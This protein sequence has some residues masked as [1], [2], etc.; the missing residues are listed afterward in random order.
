MADTETDLGDGAQQRVIEQAKQIRS[1]T[2]TMERE[3]DRANKA[4]KDVAELQKQIETLQTKPE[5]PTGT[6]ASGKRATDTLNRRLGVLTVENNKL[7]QD[8]TK[9]THALTRE[10]GDGQWTVQKV[11]EEDS[12]WRGRAQQIALLRMKLKQA[13]QA[14]GDGSAPAA[15]VDGADERNRAHLEDMKQGMRS[16]IT[17]LEAELEAERRASEATKRHN[18]SLVARA[19]IIERDHG[20]MR[21]KLKLLVQKTQ[22]DNELIERLQ[23]AAAGPE[24]RAVPATPGDHHDEEYGAGA[25]DRI[26]E[27][28]ADLQARDDQLATAMAELDELRRVGQAEEVGMESTA[29]YQVNALAVETRQLQETADRYKERNAEL[30]QSLERVT[31][32]FQ[33]ERRSRMK[34]DRELGQLKSAGEPPRPVEG[35]DEQ[36]HIAEL[37]Q[38][39]EFMTEDQNARVVALKSTLAAKEDEVLLCRQL[40]A[41][42]KQAYDAALAE[43]AHQVRGGAGGQSVDAAEVH[44]LRARLNQAILLLDR[45]GIE[46]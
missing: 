34:V 3:K 46:Y 21:E 37:E 6:P 42:H 30:S 1:M 20:G 9:L 27:L 15:P 25:M 14:Q 45:N 29:R 13:Q 16:R 10:I 32:Q 24:P 44:D 12:K 22:H 35:G 40:V 4:E 41:E 11:M 18:S 26:S 36:A 33:D 39:L 17:E 38:E 28:E 8:I 5:R 23:A 31:A 7:K 43:L 2:V 19:K